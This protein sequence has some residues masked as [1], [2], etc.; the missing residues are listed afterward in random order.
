MIVLMAYF[1]LKNT[2]KFQFLA[3]F[4]FFRYCVMMVIYAKIYNVFQKNGDVMEKM[5]VEMVQMKLIVV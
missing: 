4:M 1:F 3:N 2:V 5:I